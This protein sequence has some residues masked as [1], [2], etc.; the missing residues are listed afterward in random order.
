M[1]ITNLTML[2]KDLFNTVENVIE[3][4]E[5]VTINTKKGNA[6]LISE[7]EYNSLLESAYLSSVP[8]LVEKIK[9]GEK[10]NIK[11]MKIYNPNE[12]WW[13]G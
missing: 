5:P 11:N 13:C 9:R 8:G 3:Y 4:D 6:V 7:D 10:E 12:E 1:S 2:R